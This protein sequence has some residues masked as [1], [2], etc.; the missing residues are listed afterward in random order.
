M[1]EELT[2]MSNRCAAVVVSSV[3]ADRCIM[4]YCILC[5]RATR[6]QPAS[7]VFVIYESQKRSADKRHRRN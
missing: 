2:A 1:E 6:K 4:I 5:A 3:P 7:N